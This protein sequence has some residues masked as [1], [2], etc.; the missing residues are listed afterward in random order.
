VHGGIEPADRSLQRLRANNK[1]AQA[2]R[3]ELDVL[4]VIVFPRRQLDLGFFPICLRQRHLALLD[5]AVQEKPGRELHQAGRKAH[6]FGGIGQR[7]T[8]LELF[9][10]LASGSIEIRRRLL[11]QRHAVA[12]EIR[13]SLGARQSLPE[14]N[15]S[16]DRLLGHR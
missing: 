10:F 9:G 5:G 14:G 7:A 1:P 16:V 12:E 2:V 6:A 3:D 11:H 4:L 15:G 13:E 8:A